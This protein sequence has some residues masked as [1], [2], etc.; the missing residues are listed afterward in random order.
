MPTIPEIRDGP[1]V[2]VPTAD[3]PAT[4]YKISYA[5]T[6]TAL[7]TAVK[8]DMAL[9]WQPIGGVAGITSAIWAQA[10]VKYG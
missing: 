4:D 5:T 7:V 9:G 2:A 6:Y 1:K 10:M 8:A 3:I